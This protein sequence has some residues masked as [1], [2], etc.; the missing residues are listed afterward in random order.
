MAVAATSSP[1][2][3]TIFFQPSPDQHSDMNITDNRYSFPAISQIKIQ[4]QF[5]C[6]ARIDSLIGKWIG[7]NIYWDGMLQHIRDSAQAESNRDL[8]L[9]CPPSAQQN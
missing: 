5:S 7:G 8:L 4:L 3:G 9:A 6:I 1:Q 2:P